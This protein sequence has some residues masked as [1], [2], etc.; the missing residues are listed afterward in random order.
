MRILRRRLAS[1][2]LALVAA[3]SVVLAVASATVWVRSYSAID[4]F[5][6][7]PMTK[8]DGMIIKTEC[9]GA[10]A[11]GRIRFDYGR[12]EFPDHN[13][14]DIASLRRRGFEIGAWN[15]TVKTVLPDKGLD[16]GPDVSIGKLVGVR[17]W[18]HS[19][20]NLRTFR[21]R[22]HCATITILL[23]V[24]AIPWLWLRWRA[25]RRKSAGRCDACGYD[26]RASKARC[27][28]CGTLFPA[29][30]SLAS[31]EQGTK[32]TAEIPSK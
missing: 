12:L 19:E 1:T 25:A 5:R 31:I 30:R 16:L 18:S 17:Y 26:L 15:T 3:L 7:A 32:A 24:P 4:I 11:L 20:P 27:P 14:T 6:I 21:V 13:S 22:I 2:L 28:E 8:K 23:L 9:T 29:S 10:A